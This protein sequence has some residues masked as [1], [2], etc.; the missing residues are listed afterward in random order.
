MTKFELPCDVL[1][2]SR[3]QRHAGE[4]RGAWDL[5]SIDIN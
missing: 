1:A 5:I 4:E 3:A 2:S